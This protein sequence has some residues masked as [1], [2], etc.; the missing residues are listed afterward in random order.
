MVAS[1][2]HGYTAY[3]GAIDAGSGLMRVLPCHSPSKA[4]AQR[5]LE[6]LVTDLR[7]FMGLTHRLAPHVIV[8][9]QGSQ[10]MS[11]FF[12]DFL[13]A[14]QIRH[15]PAVVY[16]PQQNDLIERMWGTRFAMARVL[17]K[18]ANLGP[19]MHPLLCKPQTGSITAC[20]NLPGV[21]SPL[22]TS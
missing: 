4:D 3:C 6:L 14:E 7:L 17:L 20:L 21:T 1:S 19:N 5:C 16:T 13:S 18:A 15:W 9:D 10:F 2:P 8:T 11:H 22:S 12:R